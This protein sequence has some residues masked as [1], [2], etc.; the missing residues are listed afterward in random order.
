[1][2]KGKALVFKIG[3]DLVTVAFQQRADDSI[4]VAGVHTAEAALASTAKDSE[5]DFFSLIISIM[6]Q[7]KLACPLFGH[8]LMETLIAEST[9]RHLQGAT[10][11]F[12]PAAD[13]HPLLHHWQ[14]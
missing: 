9:C 14:P 11:L 3:H 10:M 8:Y 1:L 6:A 12:L 13:F 4:A 7:G 5:Q 2:S